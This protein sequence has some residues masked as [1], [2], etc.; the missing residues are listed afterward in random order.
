MRNGRTQM[1]HRP[2]TILNS[3]I[4]K[5]LEGNRMARTLQVAPRATRKPRTLKTGSTV[6]QIQLRAYEIFLERNGAPGNEIEDWL[7]AERELARASKPKPRRAA[8]APK[9]EAA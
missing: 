3:E 2:G 5:E 1:E 7:Q 6:E 9:S 8:R 4:K